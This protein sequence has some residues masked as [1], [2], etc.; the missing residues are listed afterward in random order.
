M[1]SVVIKEADESTI[2]PPAPKRQP[3]LLVHELFILLLSTRPSSLAYRR[4]ARFRSVCHL[5]IVIPTRYGFL[6]HY[7]LCLRHLRT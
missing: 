3:R 1:R 7:S 5:Q 4:L 6:Q 2:H